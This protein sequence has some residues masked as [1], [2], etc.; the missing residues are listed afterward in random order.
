MAGLLQPGSFTCPV[1][2]LL[3]GKSDAKLCF[4]RAG[5]RRTLEWINLGDLNPGPGEKE[6]RRVTME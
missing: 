3:L 6:P 2:V 1:N 4:T 5:Q